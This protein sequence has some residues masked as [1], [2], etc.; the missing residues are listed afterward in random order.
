MILSYSRLG[1]PQGLPQ[2]LCVG[3]PRAQTPNARNSAAATGFIHVFLNRSAASKRARKPSTA[4]E[5]CV[6]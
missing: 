2:Y 5:Y 1:K 6:Q 3:D 4:T